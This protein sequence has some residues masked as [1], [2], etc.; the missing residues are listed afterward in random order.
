V[1]ENGGRLLELDRVSRGFGDRFSLEDISL[2]LRHGEIHVITGENG[3]GKSVL[4][5][6][7]A[8]MYAPESGGILIEG[9]PARYSSLAEARRAGV[10][11]QQ[12]DIELF[13]NLSVAENIW[14]SNRPRRFG[15]TPGGDRIARRCH[16]LFSHLGID[17]DPD[18]PVARLGYAQ[19]LLVA[20]CGTFAAK[21]RIVI[22]DEPTAGMGES[23]RNVFFRILAGIR[24]R[25]AGIFYVTHRLEEIPAVGDRL[26]VL[27]QGRITGHLETTGTDRGTIIKM[28]IGRN[29]PERY[30]RLA[31]DPG[32]VVL[33]IES[34]A[35]APA[36]S[37]VSFKL[38]RGEI[39]GLTGH[40][41]SGRTRLANCLYGAVRPDA[42][43]IR[44][45]GKP[46][47]FRH[48][49]DALER[50]IAMIPEDR[51][52]D[53]IFLR[54]DALTNLVAASLPRFKTPLGL[55]TGYME[56][57][58]LEYFDS[59]GILPERLRGLI[60]LY[61]GGNQQKIVIARWL[62][63]LAR[64]FIMDEPTRGIDAAARVDIYNAMNDI[65]SKG[66]SILLISSDTE[67]LLGMCDRILVLANGRIARELDR[68]SATKEAL[69]DLSSGA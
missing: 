58:S 54:Q 16:I 5:K 59:F 30:P 42:G 63:S 68:A 27:Q 40:M 15:I 53:A 36:L 57:L 45:D 19:K 33:S 8:G 52:Y 56:E 47:T 34:L 62:M 64:V 61:S 46:V 35:S 51:R 12:Q 32:S 14:F 1:K 17:I 3:S 29:C 24:R 49:A 37:D 65:V 2:D 43:T 22:F 66:A 69:L 11:Y 28:M 31:A 50:G 44:L 10:I 25:G 4:M 55:D 6:L 18:T 39:L 13:G 26:T 7:I 21:G 38:R 23:E 60:H 20:A 67:E 9:A 41:G 48:P